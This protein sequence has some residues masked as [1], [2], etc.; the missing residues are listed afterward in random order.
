MLVKVRL[1]DLSLRQVVV[2]M[3]CTTKVV[4]VSSKNLGM[5][6]STEKM[7]TGITNVLVE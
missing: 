4:V 1:T 6:Y 7:V 3:G 5:L 2:L